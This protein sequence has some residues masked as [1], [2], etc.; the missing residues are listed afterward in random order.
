MG[1]EA[2]QTPLGLAALFLAGAA[3]AAINSFAGGGTLISFPV[4]VGLQVPEKIAN[5]TNSFAL[6][7][8]SMAGA[9]GFREH[10]PKMK[11]HLLD[12]LLPTILGSLLGAWLL[13]TTSDETF[14]A[15]VPA[16]ILLATLLLAFQPQIRAKFSTGKKRLH[17]GLGF[18]LQMLVSIYG[19]YFGAGTG[20]LML[21]SIGLFVEASLHEL[22]LIKNWL[23]LTI[24]FAASALL[25]WQGLVMWVPAIALMSGAIIGG[26]LAARWSQKV[27]SER[28]RRLIVAYG[29]LMTG[30]FVW[31]LVSA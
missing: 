17:P 27:D 25:I 23:A 6:W 12:L 2:F 28:L 16:L 20:I 29:F 26:Y 13:V 18:V 7:P 22:N 5:A 31:R 21:A 14:R 10:L 15:I 30:W 1:P 8:G 11:G 9:F 24:N 4:V 19:G 3:A